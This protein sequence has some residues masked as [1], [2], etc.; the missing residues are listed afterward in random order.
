MIINKKENGFQIFDEAGNEYFITEATEELAIQ[1]YNEI[2]YREVNPPPPSY[3][4]LRRAEY[5]SAD[6]LIVALW[7][8]VVEGR[9]E[10][11][12]DLQTKREAIK[13]K[14]PKPS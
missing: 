14:Y 8:K 5:P 7:E 11:A 3:T 10:A 6:E 1:K 13:A 12:A 9:P 4:E 2:K